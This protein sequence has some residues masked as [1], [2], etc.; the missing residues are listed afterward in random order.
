MDEQTGICCGGRCRINDSAFCGGCN[1]A[2]LPNYVCNDSVCLCGIQSSCQED[3]GGRCCD[4][5][6]CASPTGCCADNECTSVDAPKCCRGICIDDSLCC[7]AEDCAPPDSGETCYRVACL[8][9]NF[10]EYNPCP[11]CH[12]E[13]NTCCPEGS[14]LVCTGLDGQTFGDCCDHEQKCSAD[15]KCCPSD[16]CRAE[17]G[18]PGECCPTF[19]QCDG[20]AQCCPE[21][22]LGCR[23]PGT[24]PIGACC[25]SLDRCDAE[26]NCCPVGEIVCRSGDER[27]ECCP[28][29]DRCNADLNC[30][31]DGLTAC[32][33]GDARGECCDPDRCDWT[34][35][36]CPP[37]MVVCPTTTGL[38]GACCSSLD[39]CTIHGEC[40][41]ADQVFCRDASD[42]P[43]DCCDSIEDCSSSGVCCSERGGVLCH[44]GDG[45]PGDC[46]DTADGCNAD[47]FCCQEG[48][49]RC[50]G[51]CQDCASVGDACND[52]YCDTASGMCRRS[53]ARVGE[54]CSDPNDKCTTSECSADGVCIFETKFCLDPL[55]PCSAGGCDPVSGNCVFIPVNEGMSCGFGTT[56]GVCHEGS[57]CFGC[58]IDGECYDHQE[59]NPENMCEFCNAAVSRSAWQMVLCD[60]VDQCHA[61]SCD[62]STG[63]SQ[64]PANEGE[65]CGLSQCAAGT[66]QG[67]ECIATPVDDGTPCVFLGP[68]A[69]CKQLLTGT[70]E[71]GVC[72]N[73][74]VADG[75]GCGGIEIG[76]PCN[77][78]VCQAG[79]CVRVPNSAANG[80]ICGDSGG[81]ECFTLTCN[82]G[83]CVHTSI[84][85]WGEVC[86]GPVSCLKYEC[87]LRFGSMVCVER[88]AGAHNCPQTDDELPGASNCSKVSCNEETGQCEF[89]GPTDF[90]DQ[91]CYGPGLC[92]PGQ[93][94][95]CLLPPPE[96]VGCPK[97]CVDSDEVPPWYWDEFGL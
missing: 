34:L 82:N 50:G 94:C 23:I 93:V 56:L 10:C 52:G 64:V 71:G 15:L 97:M 92:C 6:F 27:G 33:S 8:S 88:G 68:P 89:E 81:D 18:D 76:D 62:P 25:D 37:E 59:T 53:P 61:N 28:S 17:N 7:T 39:K 74:N 43:R 30:C 40:C 84:K 79:T 5:G 66:C 31:S 58:V 13:T 54:S 38:N 29:D 26:L 11:L 70:C 72:I 51:A 83:D 90:L 16:T 86:S 77:H 73:A 85:A 63:C 35:S 1:N 2:C 41:A 24:A 96:E 78:R 55:D 60:A 4:G 49:V 65:P 47:G 12:P 48:W 32:A 91:F 19:A 69:E 45:N 3:L 44:D 22:Q 80:E 21:G 36:C 46:C 42:R 9:N 75:T 20:N 57:C 14:Q 87:R 95:V 67:G